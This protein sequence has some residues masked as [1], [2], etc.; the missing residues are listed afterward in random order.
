MHSPR[1]AKF[2]ITI[3][4]SLD[5]AV[6]NRLSIYQMDAET[7]FL[8]G[9]LHEDVY[10]KQANGYDDGTGRVY[11]SN[12][13]IY[14]SKKASRMWNLKLNDVLINFGFIRSKT[15]PCVYVKGK[16]IVAVY[17]DDFFNLLWQR[18]RFDAAKGDAA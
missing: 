14:G 10:M 2:A 3:R 18:E 17:M 15:D 12:R 7:A 6:K 4:Y 8:Q 5:L 1:R 11:H 9:D 13:V 16:L